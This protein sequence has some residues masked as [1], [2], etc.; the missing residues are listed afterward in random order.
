MR[1]RYLELVGLLT[2]H[3]E[4]I[5]TY[6]IDY[7]YK[8]CVG[9]SLEGTA[10][11]KGFDWPLSSPFKEILISLQNA[12]APALQRQWTHKTP[13]TTCVLMALRNDIEPSILEGSVE[14]ALDYER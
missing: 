2:T 8:L 1:R 11:Q 9:G 10:I 14:W 6:H 4:Y 13:R 5:G 3:S 12:Y 7:I